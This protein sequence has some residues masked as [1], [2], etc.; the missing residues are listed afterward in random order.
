LENVGTVGTI[1]G[2][3]AS[4]RVQHSGHGQAQGD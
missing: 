4:R 3:S 1:R 2:A